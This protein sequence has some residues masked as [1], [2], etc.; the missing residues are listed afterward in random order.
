M[1]RHAPA[2]QRNRAAIAG[3]L[4]EELPDA[5]TVLEI[6]SGTGEHAI[7]FA[8]R[9][10]QLAW[11]PSDP[12][13]EALTSIAA[14]RE[15]SALANLRAPVA[16]DASE[17][18]WP[19]EEAAAILCVNMIHI[20][21]PEATRGL[22]AGAG[23]L[24]N[25][26]APLILYGPFFEREVETAPS[27]LAFDAS[28]KSRDPRWGIRDVAWLDELASAAGLSRTRRVEMPANNLMLVYRK[29]A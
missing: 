23:R 25:Q 13:Q 27:N 5:G 20:S 19:R 10:T 26:G 14:Y 1:K 8:R 24:L 21:P 16:L 6:A 17:H 9:F 11:Q 22:L 29:S 4:A 15:E 7:Y 12:D 28:L 3:V 2:T 18:G